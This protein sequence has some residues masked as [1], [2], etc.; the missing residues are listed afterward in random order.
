MSTAFSILSNFPP[1]SAFTNPKILRTAYFGWIDRCD[2]IGVIKLPYTIFV[3]F[4]AVIKL[5][6]SRALLAHIFFSPVH[7][8][9]AI[10]YLLTYLRV[11]VAGASVCSVPLSDRRVNGWRDVMH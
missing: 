1:Y 6:H 5:L 10:T 3:V 2:S 4:F 8:T 9:I 11:S 7:F